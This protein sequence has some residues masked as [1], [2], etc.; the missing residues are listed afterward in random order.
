M[1]ISLTTEG[2]REII[3]SLL[4][5]GRNHRVAVFEEINRQFLQYAVDFF[6]RVARA[7][8]MGE[9]LR[10][11]DWYESELIVKASNSNETAIHAGV[12]M[13]TIENVHGSTRREVVVDAGIANYRSLRQTM[14]ELL[15]VRQPEVILTIKLG[16]V[17]VDLSVSESLIVINSLAVK[18]DQIRGG[19]WSAVGNGAE[20][21]LMQTLCS[22]FRVPDCYARSADHKEF[23]TQIDYVLQTGSDIFPVEVKLSGKGNPE[24]A[25][26]AIAHK[27]SLFVA[28][29]I[30]ETSRAVL[31][32]AGVQWVELGTPLGYLRFGNA[33]QKFD[34]PHTAPTSLDH[35]DDVLDQVLE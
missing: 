35:L 4:M 17:G 32:D 6:A 27:V 2:K 20:K 14:E 19:M 7:K 24:T 18:R 28:D 26:A 21:P 31:E 1:T 33:L 15:A 23:R 5:E 10:T 22:L 12:P 25:K 9:E 16:G 29:M 13:K 34:I 3:R 8:L 11:D 30:G